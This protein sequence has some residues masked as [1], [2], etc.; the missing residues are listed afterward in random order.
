MTERGFV[1]QDGR[2]LALFVI[3]R[4]AGAFGVGS[5]TLDEAPYEAARSAVL[6]ALD[7]AQRP[8]ELP[9]AVWVI[10]APGCEEEV[11]QGIAEVLGDHIPLIGGSSA[12]NTIEGRWSQLSTEGVYQNTVVIAALYPRCRVSTAFHSGYDPLSCRG[13]VTMASGRVLKEIDGRP[14]TQV[15]NE[16]SHGAI[17][18]VLAQGGPL[19]DKTNLHPIGRTNTWHG[20]VEHYC[21]SHPEHSDERGEMTLFTEVNVGD[22][23]VC[24]AGSVDNLVA[25]AGNVARSAMSLAEFEQEQLYA[26]LIIFCAG[27][28]LTIQERIDEARQNIRQVLGDVPFLAAF[29]FGEQ[30][31]IA[32]GLNRHGN[33]MISTLLFGQAA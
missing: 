32:G 2:A 14:A 29:T 12:D 19:P 11:V 6:A 10:T 22:E 7:D 16:W 9:E 21:L 1:G 5:A 18:S 24:M 3:D 23:L 31:N 28:F 33:L 27:C 4:S 17:E 30:G 13:V 20:G 26:G 25:R 15:Y 8:G